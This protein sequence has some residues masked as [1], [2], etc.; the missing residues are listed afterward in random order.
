M[1]RADRLFR[2]T[3]ELDT[4]RYLTARELAQLLEVSQRTIYRD[5]DALSTSGVPIEGTAGAGYRLCQGFR[6]PPLMF[7]D[8]ELTALLLG[9]RMVQ[10][11]SDRNL[12]AAA[13]RL[14]RKIE[15]ILPQRLQ[16]I[17][18][19]EALLVPDFHLPEMVREHAARLRSAINEK[20]RVWMRYQRADKLVSE[21]VVWPLGLFY[22]GEKWT[23]GAWCE[24]RGAFRQFRLDRIVDLD[25]TGS[26]YRETEGRT[27]R[28]LLLA[29]NDA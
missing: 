21:R 2:I 22:W 25:L 23:L 9:I 26:R 19:G 15:A 17:V 4:K 12:A 11:W 1:R 13:A 7:D 20:E 5:I 14:R 27:L 10:A 28:D 16:P 29:V 24:L 6:L 8:E 3:Q 18:D